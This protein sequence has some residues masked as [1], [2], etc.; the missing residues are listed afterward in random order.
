MS[1]STV[2][3]VR[4]PASL[5]ETGDGHPG[6]AWP[7]GGTRPFFGPQTG[8]DAPFAPDRLFETRAAP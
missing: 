7:A 1:L 6:C 5:E 4:R 8:A 3:D 2:T